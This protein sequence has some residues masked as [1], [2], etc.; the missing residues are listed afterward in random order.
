MSYAQRPTFAEIDLDAFTRNVSAV[1]AVLPAGSHLIAVLKADA[2]GHGAVPL[3]RICESVGVEMIA[4]ALLEEADE[5]RGAGVAVPTLILDPLTEEQ[6]E[7]ALRSGFILGISGPEGLEIVD[8][9]VKRI[10]LGAHVHLELDSGMGRLGLIDDDLEAAAAILGSNQ[11]I[12]VD[13]LFSHY[14]CASVHGD[15]LTGR[16]TLKFREM[17]ARLAELGVR[18]PLAHLANS[19]AVMQ[20]LV[21]PGDWVRSGLALFGGEA[22]ESGSS[23]LEP[24]MTLRSTIARLKEVEPGSSIGYGS[25]FVTRCRSRIATVPIGYADGYSRLMSNRGEALVRGCRAPVAGRVSMDLVTL[26]VTGIPGV[27]VGDEVVVLGGQGQDRIS[28]EEI[29]EKMGTIPYEVFC[30]INSRVPRLY[31]AKD[32]SMISGSR[33]STRAGETT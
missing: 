4:V 26:D 11:A 28:A 19:A 27:A 5:L 23:A 33:V 9:I 22:L 29:A 13:A 30:M 7:I 12:A 24:V 21:S 20:G 1:V 25:T 2:Y 32:G 8:R 15:P 14:A 31:Q 16:Q 18:A 10:G 17:C 3:A 6:T